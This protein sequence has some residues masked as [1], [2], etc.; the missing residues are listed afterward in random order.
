MRRSRSVL[1]TTALCAAMTLP[2]GAFAQVASQAATPDSSV[3]PPARAALEEGLDD[4]RWY[5]ATGRDLVDLI[6]GCETADCMSY[7]AGMISGLATRAYIFGEEHPFCAG[8]TAHIRDI[9]D[10]IITVVDADPELASQPSSFA[11]LVAF[12]A[13]WPCADATGP[14]EGAAVDGDAA[15]A[16]PVP[17]E[18]LT[19]LEPGSVLTIIANTPASLE[20]GDPAA[21]ILNTLTVFHD[22]NCPHCAAFRAETDALVEQ[23][24]R[25]RVVPVGIMSSDSKGYAALMAAF[26]QTRPDAVEALY[27]GAVP[28]QATVAAGL[29]ILEGLGIN[30]ADALSAVSETNAYQAVTDN[31]QRMN[32]LGAQGTPT[33]VLGDYLVTG[34]LEADRIAELATRL[35]TPPG[36]TGLERPLGQD[37]QTSVEPLVLDEEGAPS[38]GET[39]PEATGT[40]NEASNGSGIGSDPQAAPEGTDTTTSERP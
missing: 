19:A 30:A 24:W 34:G 21:P 7:T 6:E 33:W 5:P 15:A 18:A 11:V 38:E 2:F 14:V 35:P 28:T 16:M 1:A 13:T 10:A 17:I 39:S 3:E 8:D 40:P 37:A 22:V 25:I 23:G 12:N 36:A 9:R 4:R 27:R 29:T 32:A 26:A 20:K 31:E